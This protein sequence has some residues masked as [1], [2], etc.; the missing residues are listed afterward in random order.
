MPR[1]LYYSLTAL[2]GWFHDSAINF[3]V[4]I[5]KLFEVIKSFV[6]HN[7]DVEIAHFISP[8]HLGQRRCIRGAVL[9]QCASESKLYPAM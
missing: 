1:L 7:I 5:N 4:H 2:S 8:V 9:R 3:C 6:L